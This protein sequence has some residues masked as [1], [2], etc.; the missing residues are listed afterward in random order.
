MYHE[1]NMPERLKVGQKVKL[2][3]N[4]DE[5]GCLSMGDVGILIMGGR[6]RQPYKVAHAGSS[7][8][9][10]ETDLEPSA[11]VRH[12]ESVCLLNKS[13]FRTGLHSDITICLSLKETEMDLP[14]HKCVLATSS[15][16]F[17]KTFGSSFLEGKSAT[18][19]LKEAECSSVL[20]TAKVLSGCTR[21]SFYS[22]GRWQWRYWSQPAEMLQVDSLK[23]QACITFLKESLDEHTDCNTTKASRELGLSALED[24]CLP[25]LHPRSHGRCFL[26]PAH[27]RIA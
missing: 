21:A 1:G 26:Q 22:M 2:A 11:H 18:V 3:A 15:E 27:I 4:A 8:W 5:E 24:G 9:C 6:D 13:L 25:Q 17:A 23:R 14:L 19:P 7:H 12:V 20:A 10:Q 16:Y